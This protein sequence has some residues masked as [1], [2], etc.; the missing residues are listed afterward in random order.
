M[1]LKYVLAKNRVF[2]SL[3]KKQK[4]RIKEEKKTEENCAL[5]MEM[6]AWG[7]DALLFGRSRW[8]HW[9]FQ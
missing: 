6:E 7:G 4:K 1:K 5:V 8:C 3:M 9:I 2:I